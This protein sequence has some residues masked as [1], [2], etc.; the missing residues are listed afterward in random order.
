M[1]HLRDAVSRIGEEE[2]VNCVL[3][4]NGVRNAFL[5]QYIDY[6]ENSPNE[7]ESRQKLAGIRKY[8]PGLKHSQ[9]A[10]GMIISKN[11]Y[12]WDES[13]EYADM[14]RILGFPCRYDFDYIL[15][16]P[17]KS[18][19]TI[20]II[21][22]LNPGGDKDKVQIMVYRCKNLSSYPKAIAFAK[23]AEQALKKDPLIGPII[24]SVKAK[25]TIRL[26]QTRRVSKPKTTPDG[27]RT[28]R[29]MKT[30]PFQKHVKTLRRSQ[31]SRKRRGDQVQQ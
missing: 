31:A 30:K 19:V 1:E 8:F 14:G 3:V 12:T 2:L 27:T 5:L 18:S 29:G 15:N 20:E 17:E 7:P 22:H 9:S 28:K 25:K 23:E 4:E 16:H 11:K 21:V 24:K 26:G 13:Y 6:R 10:Q